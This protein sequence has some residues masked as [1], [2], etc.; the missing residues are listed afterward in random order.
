MAFQAVIGYLFLGVAVHAPTHRHAHPWFGGG[1][2]AFGNIPMAGLAREFSQDHMPTMRKEDVIGLTVNLF[3]RNLFPLRSK[4]PNLLLFWV[5]CDRFFVAL[6]ADVNIRQSRK[7][8][9]FEVTVAG[10]AL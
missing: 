8:L 5:F 1:A 4:L 3:P 9:S 6:Q 2:L 10:V 7:V